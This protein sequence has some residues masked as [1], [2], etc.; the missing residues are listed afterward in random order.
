MTW[1]KE[2]LERRTVSP[3]QLT[4]APVLAIAEGWLLSRE[5]RIGNQ[6]L[7]SFRMQ[8]N[9][10]VDAGARWD[11][12]QVEDAWDRVLLEF[13]LSISEA[14]VFRGIPCLFGVHAL[15]K[16]TRWRK[17][18]VCDFH[19]DGAVLTLLIPKNEVA[20]DVIISPVILHS[21][22]PSTNGSGALKGKRLADGY[23]LHLLIDPPGERFGSGLEMR[24]YPFP[25]DQRDSL[26]HLDLDSESPL[27]LINKTHAGLKHIFEDRSKT[28]TRFNLRNSLFSFIAVD[29]WLQLAQFAGEIAKQELDDDQDPRVILSR[30]IIRSLTRMLKLREDEILR[31]TQNAA[32]RSHLH[33]LLQHHFH[34]AGHQNALASGLA[35]ESTV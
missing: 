16:R 11:I 17:A 28:G 4:Q 33:R 10:I 30:K 1:F 23:P 22:D 26:F 7:E 29:V 14:G 2:A 6:K 32:D 27:L 31:A 9:R 3:F 13:R 35:E 18:E 19:P 20:G 34:L 25:E 24:W 15:C 5:N 12:F 21:G 8:R